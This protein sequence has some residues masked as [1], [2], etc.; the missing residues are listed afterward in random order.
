MR[1]LFFFCTCI[2]TMIRTKYFLTSNI[3]MKEMGKTDVILGI[4]I[5]KKGD[6]ITLIS[7][8][9]FGNFLGSLVILNLA[10][11]VNLI[12]LTL[13]WRKMEV[14][15]LI[16]LNMPKLLEGYNISWIIY[17]VCRLSGYTHNMSWDQW[18]A[19]ARLMWYLKG[20]MNYGIVY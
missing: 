20:S 2:H 8:T 18:E 6:I 19:R 3:D 7:Q 12:R 10:L 9:L 16:N 13:A 1:C 14:T 11:W 17:T 5:T 4:I 15:L